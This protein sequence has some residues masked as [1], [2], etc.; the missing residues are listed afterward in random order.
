MGLPSAVSS[1]ASEC[2][3]RRIDRAVGS[4][5]RFSHL[6]LAEQRIIGDILTQLDDLNFPFPRNDVSLLEMIQNDIRLLVGHYYPLYEYYRISGLN[7]K[8]V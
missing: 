4:F 3:D 1:F 8:Y 2:G 6:G 5:L 7:V